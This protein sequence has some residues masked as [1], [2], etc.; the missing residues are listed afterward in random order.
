M[1][2]EGFTLIEILLVIVI[3]AIL[4]LVVFLNIQPQGRIYDATDSTN[5]K[6]IKSVLSAVEM[7]TVDNK[8]NP[9]SSIP[10]IPSPFITNNKNSSGLGSGFN[11]TNNSTGIPNCTQAG[12]N[13]NTCL[14]ITNAL[15][16]SQIKKYL[17]AMPSGQFY[18][19]RSSGGSQIV[20]F[21]SSMKK[22]ITIDS[23]GFGVGFD[24]YR[25]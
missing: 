4:A 23:K 25:F 21:S 13:T 11:I 14:P 3:I 24:I 5:I 6:E 15:F 12:A 1:K 18:I 19:A 22:G 20:V 2:N 17:S 9:P 7:Y 10:F 16:D 8:G